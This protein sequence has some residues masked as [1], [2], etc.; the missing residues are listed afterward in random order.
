[1]SHERNDVTVSG[2]LSTPRWKSSDEQGKSSPAPLLCRRNMQRYVKLVLELLCESV[3]SEAP[4][5]APYS[6]HDSMVLLYI[7]TPMLGL[8]LNVRSMSD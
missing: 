2:T 4:Q 6:E 1:M 7:H 3:N 5:D 8:L